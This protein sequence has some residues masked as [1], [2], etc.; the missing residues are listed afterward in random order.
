MNSSGN[1][2][3]RRIAGASA[4]IL[5]GGLAAATIAAP[6]AVAAP[7]QC[8]ADQVANTVSS[9]TGE[10]RNYLAAHPGANQA[11]TSA[12]SQPSPAAEAN[13]RGYFTANSQEYYELR[14]ILAPI[15]ETQRTCNVAVLSPDLQSAYDQF[16]AG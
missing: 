1:T 7:A 16:M 10:A 2:M 11:V 4:G 12:L 9:V 14:D 13:L 6:S 5:F 8:N 15:G 3:R